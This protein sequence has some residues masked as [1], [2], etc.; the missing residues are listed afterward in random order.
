MITSLEERPLSLVFQVVMTYEGDLASVAQMCLTTALPEW[1]AE[2]GC[3][4]A[5]ACRIEF[6]C[7]NT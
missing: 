3:T 5:I 4:C 1:S 7:A 6:Y 2:D